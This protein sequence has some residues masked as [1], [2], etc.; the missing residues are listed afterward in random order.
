MKFK[1]FVK[2]IVTVGG[3]TLLIST[4]IIPRTVSA[5]EVNEFKDSQFEVSR[6][7]NEVAPVISREFN[8]SSIGK[9]SNVDV[10]TSSTFDNQKWLI[11]EINKQLYPKM[12]DKDLT[13]NDLDKITSIY[14][15]SK[16]LTGILPEGLTYLKNL[17]SLQL[18]SNNLSGSIPP[19][20][21]QLPNLSNLRLDYNQFTGKIPEGLGNI[22]SITLQNN[23]LIGQIPE[24][25]YSNRTEENSVNVAGNQVTFNSMQKEPTI[26]DPYTFIYRNSN[27]EG[28]IVATKTFF[29][30][31]SNKDKL[32]PFDQ[33]SS[34]FI[35]LHVEHMFDRDL[36]PEHILTIKNE[37]GKLVYD[38]EVN[39]NIEIPLEN[40]SAG[41]HTL[42]FTLDDAF[43]NPNNNVSI[44]IEI[45]K[46]TGGNI[47][48]KH[49]D[50]ENNSILEDTI[51]SGDIGEDYTTELKSIDGYTFKE[52]QGSATGK[53]TSQ[54]QTV[55]YVYTKD[56][57]AGGNVTAKYI[58]S[59][60]SKISEDMVMSGNIDENYTTEQKSIKGYTFKEIQGNATGKF[61]SQA[62]TVTYIYI[63]DS[64]AGG[65]VTVKYINS[66]GNKISEDVVMSGNIGENYTTEQKIIDGYSF[67][68]VEG[69]VSGIFTQ[70][71]KIIIYIYTNNINRSINSSHDKLNIKQRK[72]II[73]SP[74]T[75]PQTGEDIS[76][77]YIE[78]I[79][80]LITLAF[81]TVAFIVRFKKFK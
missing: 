10:V 59:D 31:L 27:Y 74:A 50:T 44:F 45:K 42:T 41:Q 26:Y 33:N 64:V 48:V 54:E 29:S 66:D 9:L 35:D 77:I 70:Q 39:S 37:S 58:N 67:K 63:K 21:N 55:T 36:F 40:L 43:N 3:I 60:G 2:T 7:K 23:K 13:F 1:R 17:Q 12:I 71:N 76:R 32:K 65:N 73:K 11:D 57:V 24:S 53:F 75:L 46:P 4:A 52:I 6:D 8:A 72:S 78:G 61:T 68:K 30:N 15:P 62:Q 22:K 51:Q 16:G 18:F 28:Q 79:L 14:L 49:V 19:I 5:G 69:D 25:L 38:G 56:P 47:T 81:G 34:T 20:F 80:G